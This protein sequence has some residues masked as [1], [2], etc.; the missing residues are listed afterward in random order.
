MSGI[1]I[2]E[3]GLLDWLKAAAWWKLG[4]MVYSKLKRSKKKDPKPQGARNDVVEGRGLS[5]RRREE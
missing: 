5:H 1:E 3:D 2:C 4:V